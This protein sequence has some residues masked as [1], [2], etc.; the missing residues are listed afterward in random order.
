MNLQFFT[1]LNDG[2]LPIPFLRFYYYPVN[3]ARGSFLLPPT[4]TSG[5]GSNPNSSIYW[6]LATRTDQTVPRCLTH[7]RVILADD[8]S[9]TAY[10]IL[11]LI[12]SPSRHFLLIP[13]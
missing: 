5:D 13:N 10:S 12:L 11:N 6:H 4:M 9:A 3:D 7:M 2:T 1:Q 8:E